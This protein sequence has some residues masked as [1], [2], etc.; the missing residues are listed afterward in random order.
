MPPQF[1]LDLHCAYHQ[2]PGHD[3]DRCSALRHAIQDLINQ[4]VGHGDMF[5]PFI[6]WPEDVN[7]QVMTH[8]GRIAQAAPPVTRPFR[9]T[10]SREEAGAIPSSLHQK[11]K[12]IHDEQVI[13]V[14][15]TRDMISSSELVLQI[16]HRDDDLFSRDSHLMSLA[17]YFV[18]GLEIQPHVEEIA[19]MTITPPS[20]DRASLFSLCFLDETNDYG[21]VIEPADMIDGVVPHDEYRDEMDMLSIVKEEIQKQL[22]VGFISMVEYLEWL[23]NVVPVP[24]KDG[25]VRVCVDFRDLNKVSPKDDFPLS[26]IDLLVNSTAGHLMLSFMD[27]FSG[28]DHLAALERFFERIWKFRLR[29]NPKKCTFEVTSKKLLGHMVLPPMSGHLLLLYLSVSDMAL[30]CML[31]Q[32]D[33]LEN[34][35]AIYYLSKRMLEP[36]LASRLMRWLVFLTE[37]D[38]KYVSQ[39]SIKGSIIADHLAYLPTIKSRPIDDDFPDE[40]FVTMT[41]LSGWCMYFDGTSNHLGYGIGSGDWKTRDAKLKPYHAYLDLLI[42]KIE[43]LKYIHLLRVQ[44]QFGPAYGHL[45]DETKVQDDLPWFDDIHQFLISNTYPKATIAKDRRELRQL[46]TRFVICGETLCKR[47]IDGMLLLC[48]DRASADRVMR[49]VHARVCGPHMGGHMLACKIMRTGYFWL[50]MQTDYC[51]FVQRFPKCQMHRDLIY[52]PPL[53][54]HALTSSW[55]FLIWGIDIIG[56][57]S[58]KSSNGHEFILVAI[59]YFTK[60]AHFIA[61]VE[62]LLQKY[63]IQHHRSSASRSQTNGAVVLPVEIEM[64]S[65]KVALEQP[66]PLQKEDLVLRICRV[67]IGDPRGSLDLGVNLMLFES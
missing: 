52:I 66:R 18:R 42:E 33:D 43:E 28:V 32:L 31:A 22:S 25:N 24:K 61:E 67:L 60:G 34:E 59:D 44:N 51:Q 55:P 13:T 46:A 45:I 37:F 11:V 5:A 62:T 9:G 19:S 53:E 14:Q 65:L 58:P 23:A 7:V 38:I 56:K 41:R 64:G 17:N 30:E 47:S 16:S 3:I 20:L 1:R 50:T 63:G 35:R 49:E 36:T 57:I 39:K 54:L 8:S 48:L 40:E 4:D 29:V 12:F 21:V 15:S 2:G 26:N 10:D 27:G 6:L